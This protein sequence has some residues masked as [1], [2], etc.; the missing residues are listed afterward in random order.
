MI[1]YDLTL[2]GAVAQRTIMTL[3]EQESD[4]ANPFTMILDLGKRSA[5]SLASLV[6]LGPRRGG[7]PYNDTS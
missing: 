3:D 4:G 6:G 7:K 1:E 2:T 5:G